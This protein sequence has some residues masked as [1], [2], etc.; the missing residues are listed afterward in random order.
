[1]KAVTK[2]QAKPCL[3]CHGSGKGK[4]GKRCPTCDGKGEFAIVAKPAP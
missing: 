1:M 3:M 4:D 2:S